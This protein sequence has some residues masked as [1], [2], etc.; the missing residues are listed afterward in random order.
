MSDK[1]AIG[2]GQ[3]I[4]QTP[5]VSR[6]GV[7]SEGFV[8]D[9]SG[10]VIHT[11]Q[12]NVPG[13]HSESSGDR[14]P[15]YLP[16]LVKVCEQDLLIDRCMTLLLRRPAEFRDDGETLMS[17]PEEARVSR[18]WVT[19][20]RLNDAA[21]MGRARL[22]DEES[23][24]GSE[25]VG[26]TMRTTTTEVKGRRTRSRTI[27]RGN[28][29]WLWCSAILPTSDD[30]WAQLCSDLPP[31]HNHYWTFRSPRIF[32]RA[33]GGMV[34]DQLG[35]RGKETKL[36]HKFANEVTEHDTQTVFHGPVAYVDDPYR[37]VAESATPLERLLRP[38]FV[39]RLE[40]KGQREYRFVVWAESAPEEASALL[41]VSPILL[42]TTRGLP[43]GSVPVPRSTSPPRTPPS[44]TE[45]IPLGASP[46][47][48]TDPL[49]EG[50]FAML[51]DPHFNHAPRKIGAEDP[52]VDLE[53][54]TAVYSAVE[55]LREIVGK[56]DNEPHAAA[57]AWH[58]EPYIRRLCSAFRDPIAAIRLTEDNF[59]VIHIKY[60]EDADGYGTI[61]VGPRG[62][63]R[64]KIGRDSGFMDSTRGKHPFRG[65]PLIHEDFEESISRYGLP[66]RD[67]P[68]P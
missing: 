27:G 7:W 20:E 46:P 10:S 4:S 35:P 3:A 1:S 44:A 19:A 54:R 30:E 42:E 49:T 63:V 8:V 59:I 28:S 64:A 55:T 25:L 18:K 13:P 57:A 43:S 50:V 23:N 11:Y 67:N 34:V 33:L 45:A 2:A 21:E 29:G 48:K 41:D 40:Y 65:W 60:P 37:F 47:P 5:D 6:F 68:T 38:L 16:V 22:L 32:A 14:W 51:D 39:K 66:K 56:A 9:D 24:R 36:T 26:S 17:D 52:P 12:V 31:A 61:A 15:R 58:A 53:E 62:V